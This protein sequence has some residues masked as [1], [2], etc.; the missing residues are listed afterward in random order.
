VSDKKQTTSDVIAKTSS[1]RY[2]LKQT[3]MSTA[4]ALGASGTAE[5]ALQSPEHGKASN[6]PRKRPNIVLICADQLR[7]DFIGAYGE[8][9]TTVT[10]NLDGM[11]NRGVAFTQAVTNDPLCSP[12]RGCMITGRYALET[13]EWKLAQELRKDLPTLASELRSHGYTANFI[14]KW[15]LAKRDMKTGVGV[16]PVVPADRGGFLDLWEGANEY[17]HTTHPY[18]GTIWDRDGKPIEF[19]NQYRVEFLTDRAVRFLRQPHDKP[20]LLYVSQLEPHQQNDLDRPVA[21]NGVA[22]KFQNPFVPADL[23]HL[24]GSWQAQLPDYYGCV[25]SIDQSVGKILATLKEENLLDDTIV[26][27]ISDHGCHF[28]TR[29]PRYKQSPHD[30]SIRIAF[31]F[32]GPGF[33]Q[34]LQLREVVSMIDLTPTLLSAV[35][36]PVPASMKGRDLT[37]LATSPEARRAWDN[38]V[39][40][41]ISSTEVARALRTKE[42]CYCVAD[43]SSNG[44]KVPSS[45]HYEEHMLY[46]LYSDPAELVNVVGRIEYKEVSDQLRAELKR[47]MVLAGE[48]EAEIKPAK[49]YA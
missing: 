42:W 13:G 39:Y 33:D 44:E 40:I 48:S 1:R 15:H 45:D 31:V 27:F 4:A 28:K 41:Q 19:E 36:V 49:V 38:T 14:G 16:G 5:A 2:F 35:G 32:Q 12:S 43:T 24:P 11:V 22:E 8:N 20:F 46:N 7:P 9:P 26:V 34:S 6:A 17:E 29:N 23:L 25:Q 37:S 10:P 21:P 47:R 3:A 18:K 30:S